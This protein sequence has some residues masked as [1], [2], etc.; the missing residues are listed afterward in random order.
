VRR[1]TV[2]D[3]LALGYPLLVAFGQR[4]DGFGN[5]GNDACAGLFELR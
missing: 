4:L 1:P 5:F 2:I 3:F